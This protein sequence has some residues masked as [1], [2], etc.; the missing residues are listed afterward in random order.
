MI[1][2]YDG[3]RA[4]LDRLPIGVLFATREGEIPFCNAKAH[5]RLGADPLDLLEKGMAAVPPDTG[6]REAWERLRRQER[7]EETVE[8]SRGRC[9]FSATLIQ[10]A[11]ALFGEPCLLALVDEV[12]ERERVR[13]LREGVLGEILRRMRG[14]LTSVKTALS[15]LGS[16][17]HADIPEAAR[18]V[19]RLGDAEVRRLHGLLGDM[20]ELV[21]LEGPAPGGGLYL[22]NVALGPLLGKCLRDAAKTPAG[23]GRRILAEPGTGKA[24]LPVVADCDKLRLIL[25]HLIANALAYSGDEDPVRVDVRAAEGNRV[26]VRVEDRGIGIPPAER[27]F[28]FRKFFR[29]SHPR[30]AEKEG[31]GLGL[32]IAKAYAELMGGDLRVESGGAGRGATAV[33]SLPAPAG[34]L[35][36]TAA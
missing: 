17:A 34:G 10:G 23:R 12:T 28:L 31:S 30:V 3:L 11:A 29:G 15:V 25:D 1:L 33:L 24:S 19:V 20:T 27:P 16:E 14:P 26:E 18:E 6:I 35:P 13:D 9:L 4:V 21:S 22:E 32:F 8:F 2:D 7:G 5:E 36:G